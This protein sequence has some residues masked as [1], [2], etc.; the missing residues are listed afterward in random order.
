M[1]W[2]CWTLQ[3]CGNK[4]KKKHTLHSLWHCF[5][6]WKQIEKKKKL[7]KNVFTLLQNTRNAWFS[8]P[9]KSKSYTFG[10]LTNY[11]IRQN[12]KPINGLH[13]SSESFKMDHKHHSTPSQI[14]IVICYATTRLNFYYTYNCTAIWI[15]RLSFNYGW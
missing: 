4:K 10:V 12:E 15:I 8:S 6:V 9:R 2:K 1:R 14:R 5:V 3:I 13:S 7:Y 11:I